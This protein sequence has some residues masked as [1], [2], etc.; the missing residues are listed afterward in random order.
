VK[1]ATHRERRLAASLI[2]TTAGLAALILALSAWAGASAKAP[3]SIPRGQTLVTIGSAWGLESSFNPFAPTV[4]GTIGLCYETLLRY[5][6]LKDEYIPWLAI[7][8]GFEG[9]KY[10]ITVRKGVKFSNG[11][12]LTPRTVVWNIKLGR[13]QTASWHTLW[14]RI[15]R[16]KVKGRTIT[17]SFKGKPSHIQ[18]QHLMW[19]LPIVYPDQF[20]GLST[21]TWTTL[22]SEEGFDPIGTGPY[23][24]NHDATVPDGSNIV[25][26]ARN[27]WWALGKQGEPRKL[28]VK[29]IEDVVNTCNACG[30]LPF[31][32]VDLINNYLPGVQRLVSG[33]DAQTYYSEPPYHLCA[34]TVWLVPNTTHK[35][36][37]DR[38][39]RRALA[40]A[41]STGYI[42]GKGDYNGQVR[43]ANATGL[44]PTWRKWIDRT[45][46]KKLG[47]KRNSVGRAKKDLAAAGYR[48]VDGDGY[49]ENKDGSKLELTIEVP[50]GWSDW[51]AARNIIV[52][53]E[54]QAGIHLVIVK[55]DQ[56][57]V[58]L[59]DRNQGKFDLELDNTYQ[60][61]DNP[62]TYWN[63]IFHLPIQH[64]QTFANFER[65][66][67]KKAWR[68]VKRL[69]HTPPSDLKE[70]K[71]IAS[72]LEWIFL[73]ELPV[74]PLW[75]GGVWSQ[76][77]S[78][79]WT[80]WPSSTAK[81]RHFIPSMWPGYLQMT[82]IDMITHLRQAQ[83]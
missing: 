31:K 62:W 73:T 22:G 59:T 52:S 35:P 54:K 3:A 66:R 39:F 15:K 81:N 64:T 25:W 41:V 38:R 28:P 57:R 51:E 21:D 69:D 48:D 19:N 76:V 26:Q 60:L 55:G 9:A 68:L 36:L 65:Y 63:G 42:A 78:N 7:E 24:V 61:S 56:P 13:F 6:P 75:Y 79:R 70:R 33:G 43:S 1:T 53:T 27:D 50:M 34:N 12:T 32:I 17:V 82:G 20:S 47:F 77:S 37:G 80:N 44:L 83:P 10:V 49:V 45:Q 18:W 58:Q 23:T 5:D 4:T 40:E 72:K 2:F 67:N 46:L 14:R 71:R 8:A 29:Y 30:F 16:I 74:I 11:K